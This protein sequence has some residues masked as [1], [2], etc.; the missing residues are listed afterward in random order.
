MKELHPETEA[1]IQ[2][3]KDNPST[4]DTLIL[5]NKDHGELLTN[6]LHRAFQAGIQ[7]G[8]REERARIAGKLS[9]LIS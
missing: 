1:W 6:R 7:F 8:K 9:T 4:F 5:H 3:Q 2:F